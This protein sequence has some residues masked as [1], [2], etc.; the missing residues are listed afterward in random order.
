[1]KKSMTAALL[2]A[3]SVVLAGCGG[4]GGDSSTPAQATNSGGSNPPQSA[5]ST[6][7]PAPTPPTPPA[8]PVAN[9]VP[10]EVN[11]STQ[12]VNLA[13]V[14]VTVCQPGTSNC[15]TIPNIQLDTGSTGLRV[16]KSALPAT[17]SLA[18]ETNAATGGIVN[19]CMN[20]GGGVAWGKLVTADVKM[21]GETAASVPMQVI[22][23]TAAAVP[24]HCSSQ[25]ALLKQTDVQTNGILGIAGTRDCGSGC[26]T[27]SPSSWY[28]DCQGSICTS[29]GAPFKQQSTNP[30]TQ[31]AADNNGIVLSFP[32]LANG[33]SASV[34]GTLTFGLN[35]QANNA[36]TGVSMALGVSNG[37][38]TTYNG[39]IM[40]AALDSGS[41]VDYISSAP[42]PT[43]TIGS[44]T[45]FCPSVTTAQSASL[46]DGGTLL[47]VTFNIAN[48]QTVMAK[49]GSAYADVAQNV[50]LFGE[51][52]LVLGMS[53]LFGHNLFLGY[54]GNSGSQAMVG[55]QS[56]QATVQ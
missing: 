18:A 13:L 40:T 36:S 17:L 51:E 42:F 11:G 46:Q 14:S 54:P 33:V 15:T 9:Q 7:A 5:P 48:A 53:Y 43:C 26:V 35:T 38:T 1:M 20:F 31:F 21:A 50:S 24:T 4:G 22:D 16:F 47:S 29:Y 8:T 6:P 25:N 10:V 30:V 37:M 34:T 27:A 52:Y 55:V 32:G 56:N 3:M 39:R 41:S 49:P 2:L 19:E 23:D 12:V 45:W 28:Y 44:Q